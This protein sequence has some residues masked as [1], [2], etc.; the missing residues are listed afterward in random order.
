M[1]DE[2]I[3]VVPGSYDTAEGVP[4][5]DNADHSFAAGEAVGRFES[6]MA[7]CETRHSEKDGRIAA[8]ES[9]LADLQAT[10]A[11]GV[12]LAAVAAETAATAEAKADEAIAEGGDDSG[13]VEMTMPD[14]PNDDDAPAPESK[15]GFHLW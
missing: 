15:R 2:T 5:V 3:I 12:T 4:V 8:L 11:V 7:S 9:K 6:H 10:T 13:V 14:V 1:S